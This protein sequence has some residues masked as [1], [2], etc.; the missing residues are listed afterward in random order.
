[1]SKW[2]MYNLESIQENEKHKLYWDF[3]SQTDDLFSTKRP[4]LVTA[5]KNKNKK[6]NK[7]KAKQKK[8]PF[9]LIPE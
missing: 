9:W 2:Y 3:E 6:Q 5:H 8:L 4:D 1:M 7:N